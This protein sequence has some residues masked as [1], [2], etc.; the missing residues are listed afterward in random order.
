MF[1]GIIR[2]DFIITEM[3]VFGCMLVMLQTD[4]KGKNLFLNVGCV[5]FKRELVYTYFIV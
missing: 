2:R 4:K 5:F 3:N 1:S